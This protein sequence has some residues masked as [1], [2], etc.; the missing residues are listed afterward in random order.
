MGYE[1][2]VK[3]IDMDFLMDIS[4]DIEIQ[5]MIKDIVKFKNEDIKKFE[6]LKSYMEFLKVGNN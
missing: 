4:F 3:N 6:N 5:E 2:T 1:D